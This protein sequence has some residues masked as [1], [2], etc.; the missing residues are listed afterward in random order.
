MQGEQQY[1][2][3]S[4]KDKGEKDKDN[5]DKDDNI[6]LWPLYIVC[7]ISFYDWSVVAPS[8]VHYLK[9][10][11]SDKEHVAVDLGWAQAS[12]AIGQGV[13]S[14]CCGLCLRIVSV[15]TLLCLLT[16]IMGVGNVLYSMAQIYSS[17]HLLIWGRA[18]AGVGAAVNSIIIL[19]MSAL[20]DP[21]ERLN[22]LAFVRTVGLI[23]QCA[24]PGAAAIFSN[25]DAHS[26]V[27]SHDIHWSDETLPSYITGGLCFLAVIVLLYVLEPMPA[28]ESGSSSSSSSSLSSSSSPP[29]GLVVF[30][31]FLF[32]TAAATLTCYYF[33]VSLIATETFKWSTLGVALYFTGLAVFAG[34][35]ALT[36]RSDWYKRIN[37]EKRAWQ[38]ICTCLLVMAGCSLIMILGKFAYI[39]NEGSGI[40]VFTV[41]CSISVFTISLL[42]TAQTACYNDI[43]P[44]PVRK[45]LVPLQSFALAVGRGLT[46]IIVALE[47]A[48]IGWIL[49]FPMLTVANLTAAFSLYYL[50]PREYIQRS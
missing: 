1:H 46:P 48:H 43:L 42:S 2:S 38:V 7:F 45:T 21:N 29:Y 50:A 24:G 6:P 12:F 30:H 11:D 22:V 4:E 37:K 18:V 28:T 36:G 40:F 5:K 33:A 49:F 20:R 8:I 47:V 3:I 10:M 15:K 9:T 14:I 32:S 27:G 34:M 35:G 41:G 19:Y 31:L 16:F 44:P 25:V 26:S 39:H 13:M 17:I 23:G